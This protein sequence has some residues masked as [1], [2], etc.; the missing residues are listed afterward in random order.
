MIERQAT[1]ARWPCI[2]STRK[3]ST[4]GV[5]LLQ[6]QCLAELRPGMSTLRVPALRMYRGDGHAKQGM[7]EG[8]HLREVFVLAGEVDLDYQVKVAQVIV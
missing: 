6:Q 1:H 8:A 4:H 5:C 2:M 3:L 7:R